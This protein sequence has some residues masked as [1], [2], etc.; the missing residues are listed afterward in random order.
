MTSALLEDN[1]NPH[2]QYHLIQVD[3]AQK[4]QQNLQ[5]A[6]WTVLDICLPDCPGPYQILAGEEY[7]SRLQFAFSSLPHGQVQSDRDGEYCQRSYQYLEIN[8]NVAYLINSL[9]DLCIFCCQTL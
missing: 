6:Q 1:V 2:Q 7:L 9:I 5:A 3:F 4:M 8:L